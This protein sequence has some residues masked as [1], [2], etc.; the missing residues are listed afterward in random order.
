MGGCSESFIEEAAF[1]MIF[2]MKLEEW[3]REESAPRLKE[4]HN[5]QSV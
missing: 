1:D 2:A 5:T 3:T 4:V